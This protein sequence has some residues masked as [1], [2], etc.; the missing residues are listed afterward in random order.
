MLR[1]PF[2][3]PQFSCN[4]ANISM[5]CSNSLF[6]GVKFQ[7]RYNEYSGCCGYTLKSS[8]PQAVAQ[9]PFLN[10]YSILLKNITKITAVTT[11]VRWFNSSTV[12][13][14]F[15]YIYIHLGTQDGFKSKP[16]YTDSFQKDLQQLIITQQKSS[17][18]HLSR[19]FKKATIT[20][21]KKRKKTN[22]LL[23]CFRTS[24]ELINSFKRAP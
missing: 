3:L 6:H 9:Y 7:H 18:Q 12:Y 2:S 10:S 17:V 21:K 24:K 20:T 1:K 8:L 22:I 23:L 14:Q 4:E 15:S 16:A 11:E 5:S 13:V 19:S